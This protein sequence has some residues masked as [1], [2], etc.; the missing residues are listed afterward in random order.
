MCSISNLFLKISKM[1]PSWGNQLPLGSA[2]NIGLSEILNWSSVIQVWASRLN[3]L[4]RYSKTFLPLRQLERISQTQKMFISVCRAKFWEYSSQGGHGIDIHRSSSLNQE[5]DL[6]GYSPHTTQYCVVFVWRPA[7]CRART[8]R[9]RKQCS[10]I[11]KILSCAAG[12]ASVASLSSGSFASTTSTKS[13]WSPTAGCSSSFFCAASSFCCCIAMAL[14]FITTSVFCCFHSS[15]PWA[16][17][18]QEVSCSS[19]DLLLVVSVRS[20]LWVSFCDASTEQE[21][22]KIDVPTNDDFTCCSFKVN[23][24]SFFS[25][26]MFSSVHS[27]SPLSESLRREWSADFTDVLQVILLIPCWLIWSCSGLKNWERV[28]GWV[29]AEAEGTA[30]CSQDSSLRASFLI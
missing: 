21:L 2:T 26:A 11:S 1:R 18:C 20:Q 27:S 5:S 24:S 6:F 19:S 9:S 14:S 7:S 22:E 13:C 10:L 3:A 12:K 29:C 30:C 23:P 16:V 28:W 17:S 8:P 15:R 4:T 25:S